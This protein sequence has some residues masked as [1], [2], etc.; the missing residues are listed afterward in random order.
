[1]KIGWTS[2]LKDQTLEPLKSKMAPL[3]EA[4]RVLVYT[5]LPGAP[6]DG[7]PILPNVQEITVATPPALA[8]TLQLPVVPTPVQFTT[9]RPAVPAM[10]A[11]LTVA[12]GTGLANWSRTITE[13]SVATAVPRLAV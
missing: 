11:K 5:P 13:G 2:P 4:R 10:T 7:V 3:E 1:V 6:A 12:L 8:V 9:L